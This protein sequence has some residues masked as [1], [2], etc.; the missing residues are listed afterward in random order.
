MKKLIIALLTLL[1]AL[2]VV[3]CTKKAV[4]H[5]PSPPPPTPQ[6]DSDQVTLTIKPETMLM[7]E[8]AGFVVEKRDELTTVYGN[9][10]L[11]GAIIVTVVP[12][13]PDGIGTTCQD[14]ASAII[15]DESITSVSELEFFDKGNECSLIAAGI[16]EGK[17]IEGQA[18]ARLDFKHPEY[19]IIFWGVWEDHSDIYI[20]RMF[21]IFVE[22]TGAVGVQIKESSAK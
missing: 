20:P 14:V 18:I 13:P 17:R 4:I 7:M 21:F 10:E 9:R 22:L 19:T 6:A 12:T 11:K 15:N 16:S 3:G 1:L 2:T 5:I 8:D